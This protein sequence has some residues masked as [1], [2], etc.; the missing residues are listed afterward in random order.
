[1][2]RSNERCRWLLRSHARRLSLA[3]HPPRLS[4][5]SFTPLLTV[6]AILILAAASSAAS[7][8]HHTAAS[9]TPV[10]RQLAWLVSEANGASATLGERE[11]AAHLSRSIRVA[12]PPLKF[13]QLLKQATS[14]YS[15]IRIVGFA[16]HPTATSAIALIE[17]RM[18]QELAIYASVSGTPPYRITG[19]DVGERPEMGAAQMAMPGRYTGAFDIGGRKMFLSCSGSGS[20]T[21]ILEAGAGGG[22]HSWHAVQPWLATTTRVCSYDRANLPGGSSEP[23]HKPQTAATIV[24]DLHRL[25]SA[26]RVP[27]PYVFA[28][29]SNGGLFARLYATT[30]PKQVA[31]LILI[32]TGN[33]PAILKAFNKK[34]MSAREWRVYQASLIPHR[35]FIPF[36]GDEQIDMDASYRQM[37]KAQRQHPLRKLPFVVISHGIPDSSLKKGTE[38]GWQQAQ[39]T[40]A[41]LVPGGIRIIA[42]R[43]DHAIPTKQPGLI[44]KAI[45]GVITSVSGRTRGPSRGLRSNL[46]VAVNALVAAGSPGAIVLVRDGSRTFR[47]AGGYA[48]FAPRTPMRVNDRFRIG[49]VTKTFVATVVLQ[50]VGEG[51]L[52]LDDTVAHWLPG[53]VPNGKNITVRQLLNHTSGLADYVNEDLSAKVASNPTKAFTPQQMIARSTAQKPNFAPGAPN[54]WGYSSTNYILAGLIVEKATKSTLGKELRRRIFAPIGLR[55]T[56]LATGPRI[57]GLHANGYSSIR[58]TGHRQDVSVVTPT[59]AWAAGAMVSTVAD[60]ARFERALFQGRLLRPDLLRSMQ[61]TVTFGS[62]NAYGLGLMKTRNLALSPMSPLPCASAWGHDGDFPGYT[63]NAFSSKDGM[64]QMVVF[65][66]TDDETKSFTRALSNLLAI[67]YCG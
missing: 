26:A 53:L 6:I 35:P 58:G 51:K 7:G 13:V 62:D 57:K 30:Y 42:A 5:R 18:H 33:Y 50:L 24:S 63:T 10:D 28:G 36:V 23:A 17:T 67:A 8:S 41:K 22:S 55:Q 15:P 16:G 27:G 54:R 43:S 44:V 34:H 1:M 14:V 21:V 32:D 4:T 52:S 25:L 29:W 12:L 47:L 46:Q 31:G 56:T 19:L 39:I 61:T 45:R 38:Q 37:A 2:I 40:L 64:R 3:A 9:Q 65:A 48:R 20:P 60:L 66:N 59:W 11:A 49:S